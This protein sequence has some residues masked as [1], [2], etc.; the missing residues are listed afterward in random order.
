[1]SRGLPHPVQIVGRTIVLWGETSRLSELFGDLTPAAEEVGELRTIAVEETRYRK[2]SGGP[3]LTRRA[4]NRTFDTNRGI[5][6]L[7]R[8][9]R[10]FWVEPPDAELLGITIRN[11]PDQFTFQGAWFA[12]K[13]L[14]F[15][16]LPTG[17]VIRSTGG[18]A[19]MIP[20]AE[21]N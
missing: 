17:W 7:A 3:L 14:A 19:F 12:L 15:R 18:R 21:E 10:R 16:E 5:P 2:Y 20:E 13:A 4:H 8:P 9:G 11:N 6:N 1:M